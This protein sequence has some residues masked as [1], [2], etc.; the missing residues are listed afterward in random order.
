MKRTS[1]QLMIVIAVAAVCIGIRENVRAADE[2]VV[3]LSER[4]TAD[5]PGATG[6][7]PAFVREWKAFAEASDEP[8][9]KRWVELISHPNAI[10]LS[11]AW[12][13]WRGFD[14]PSLVEKARADGKIPAEV[15]PGLVITAENVDSIPGIDKLLTKEHIAQLKNKDWYGFK[16]IRVVPTSHYY[17]NAG[18]LKGFAAETGEFALNEETGALKIKNCTTCE[19]GQTVP[20]TWGAKSVRIPFVPNPKTGLELIYAYALHNVASDN[21]YFKPIEF[22]LCDK[23]NK[24]ERTYSAHLWWQNFWGRTTYEPTPYL[25]NTPDTKYQGG[26]I[27]FTHPLDVKGLCGARVRHFDPDIDDSF[28]VFVPFLKRTRILAGSDTQD[29]LCAGCDLIW[30]DWRSFWQRVDPRQTEYTI[31]STDDFILALPERGMVSDQFKMSNCTFDDVEMEIRPVYRLH[32]KDK[33]G[34]YVYSERRIWIDKD[35]WYM[36]EEHRYDAQGR[37]WRNWID[38]RYWDPRTGEAMWR[39]VIITDP[40]NRHGTIIKMNVDFTQAMT[41]TKQEYFDIESLKSY[42]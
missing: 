33:S 1:M 35:W 4:L 34:K 7:E 3:E 5:L 29:P 24:I 22:I 42:Q 27:F 10:K 30:D 15:K 18:R 26:A 21:L 16:K 23:N 9:D 20:E 32:L 39:N 13:K 17:L 28:A 41:G 40:I 25:P 31:E 37:M 2:P 6:D 11:N 14:A 12:S 38:V 36:Q 19:E 8:G